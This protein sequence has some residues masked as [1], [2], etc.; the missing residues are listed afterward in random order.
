VVNPSKTATLYVVV[1]NGLTVGFERVEVK[2]AGTEVQAYVYDPD[3]PL[4]TAFSCTVAPAHTIEGVA[5]G[6]ELNGLPAIVIVTASELK[7]V[8]EVDVAVSVNTVV[9][10]SITVVGSTAVG[11]ISCEAGVQL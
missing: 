7:Q 8:V 5:V 6:F 2:P 9:E 3:P 11:F 4:A 10:V 1:T